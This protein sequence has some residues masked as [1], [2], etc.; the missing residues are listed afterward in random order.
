MLT[1]RG[2]FYCSLIALI[3]SACYSLANGFVVPPTTHRVSLAFLRAQAQPSM[4][5][6]PEHELSVDRIHKA[7]QDACDD[8]HDDLNDG[9]TL[10]VGS[11]NDVASFVALLDT[12]NTLEQSLVRDFELFHSIVLEQDETTVVGFAIVYLAYSTWDGRY[13]Y[14]DH[15]VAPNNDNLEASMMHCLSNAVVRLEGQR[16]AWRH[17]DDKLPLYN[18][19]GGETLNGWLTL[20]L[21][22]EA[23][24]S[25]LSSRNLEVPETAPTK[26]PVVANDE[27][28]KAIQSVLATTKS[29]KLEWYLATEHDLPDVERLVDGLATYHNEVDVIHVNKEH[30]LVDGFREGINPLY[31][32]LLL[33]NK[34]DGHCCGMAFFYFGYNLHSGRFVFLEELFIE[35]D[36]RG[37]GGGTLT[38]AT[39]A[40]IAKCVGC[41]ALVWQSLEWDTAALRFYASIGAKVQEGLLTTRFNGEALKQFVANKPSLGTFLHPA[42]SK[43]L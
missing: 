13:L 34:D 40:S 7:I 3:L 42:P 14:L 25:F 30:Y 6:L 24:S 10:R 27:V 43:E 21:D 36:Y 12:K 18:R 15:I 37:S 31:K 26:E 28:N 38:M 1:I 16:L 5:P 41:T 4:F 29:A 8:T 33:K 35:E 32:C 19:L 20:Q 11:R 22:V 2:C 39:L 23:M 17:Y 9:Y